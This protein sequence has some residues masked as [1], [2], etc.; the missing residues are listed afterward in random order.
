MLDL[1]SG[2]H[3]TEQPL[4]SRDDHTRLKMTQ[5][6]KSLLIDATAKGHAV[7]LKQ[8]ARVLGLDHHK[9]V[10]TTSLAS[11]SERP[12]TMKRMQR[13]GIQCASA[14]NC[15]NGLAPEE[16]TPRIH[17][18]LCCSPLHHSVDSQDYRPGATTEDHNHAMTCEYSLRK[19]TSTETRRTAVV[20]TNPQQGTMAGPSWYKRRQYCSHHHRL[21]A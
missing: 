20:N 12:G 5:W 21:E 2:L 14:P 7:P 18:H 17:A 3:D 19:S 1:S 15:A 9:D 8:T 16:A 4:T 10:S 11:T 13:F 6:E